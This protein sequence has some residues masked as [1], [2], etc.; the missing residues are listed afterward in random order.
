MGV[1]YR[2]E[3][4]SSE[5]HL[6]WNIGPSQVSV[7]GPTPRAGCKTDVNSSIIT[8]SNSIIIIITSSNSNSISIINN[9][10]INS[11]KRPFGWLTKVMLCVSILAPTAACVSIPVPTATC[12]SRPRRML[13]SVSDRDGV[14]LDSQ[15]LAARKLHRRQVRRQLSP[16]RQPPFDRVIRSRTAARD[17]WCSCYYQHLS[18]SCRQ[19]CQASSAAATLHLETKVFVRRFQQVG[20]TGR[21][22]KRRRRQ[23]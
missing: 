10:T 22:E 12:L 3:E 13:R 16:H 2:R 7:A 9:S 17:R 14:P 4:A 8:S 5:M 18:C 19:G 15:R 23:H 11:S 1:D 20:G 21:G 6:H